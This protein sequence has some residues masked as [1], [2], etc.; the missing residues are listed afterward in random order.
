MELFLRDNYSTHNVGNPP[1]CCFLNQTQR[2][3]LNVLRLAHTGAATAGG[4]LSASGTGRAASNPIVGESTTSVAGP[5]PAG[6][7]TA[8]AA[9]GAAAVE[10]AGTESTEGAEVRE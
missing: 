4:R 3:N 7:A 2:Y 10:R 6:G 5:A 8:G 1:D 9:A